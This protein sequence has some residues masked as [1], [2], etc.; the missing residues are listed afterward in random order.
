MNTLVAIIDDDP[1]MRESLPDLLASLG[2][3]TRAFSSAEE[4]LA[5]D[6]I[7]ATQCLILD[8][9]MPGMSGPQLLEELQSRGQDRPTIFITGQAN[10][11]L[12]KRMLARGAVACLLKP[13]KGTEIEKA[14]NDAL[15]A[16]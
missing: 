10:E 7:H 3:E 2:H 8:I 1:S 14:L 16:A 6:C 5:S 11:G 15:R 13:F 12:F 9:S 4:Y